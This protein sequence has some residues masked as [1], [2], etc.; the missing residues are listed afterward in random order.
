MFISMLL[1]HISENKWDDVD[2]DAYG[3]PIWMKHSLTSENEAQS[4]LR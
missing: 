2:D 4:G 1:H 3:D